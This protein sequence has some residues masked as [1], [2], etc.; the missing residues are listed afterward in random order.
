MEPRLP[1]PSGASLRTRIKTAAPPALA[2][3]ADATLVSL[4]GKS[5]HDTVSRAAILVAPALVPCVRAWYGGTSTYLRWEADG[6][7]HEISQGDDCEQGD[8]WAPAEYSLA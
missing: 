6:Q 7:H 5:A 8:A 3:D 4:D 1:S 2:D